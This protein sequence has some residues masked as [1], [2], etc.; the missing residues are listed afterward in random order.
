MI[1]RAEPRLRNPKVSVV[2]GSSEWM[3]YQ[4]VVTGAI[5][6]REGQHPFTFAVPRA[7]S[8]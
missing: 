1:S 6:C 8:Q 3:P 4:L 7:E 2:K 5:A